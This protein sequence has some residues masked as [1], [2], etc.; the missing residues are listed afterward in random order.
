MPLDLG[1]GYVY[2]VVPEVLCVK[3][4]NMFG[5]V[6][7][8]TQMMPNLFYCMP[9]CTSLG[10]WLGYLFWCFFPKKPFLHENL[11]QWN[12]IANI[13]TFSYLIRVSFN[14]IVQIIDQCCNLFIWLNMMSTQLI[15]SPLFIFIYIIAF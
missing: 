1:V 7:N 10:W 8:T 5:M 13:L 15:K 14:I 11:N 3:V 2:V 4:I 6:S 12:K 9:T